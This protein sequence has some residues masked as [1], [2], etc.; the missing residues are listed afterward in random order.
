MLRCEPKRVPVKRLPSFTH[1][2]RVCAKALEYN[3]FF[4]PKKS[5]SRM[6]ASNWN[7]CTVGH[8]A[9]DHCFEITA[10]PSL[11]TKTPAHAYRTLSGGMA[12][13]ASVAAARLGAHVRLHGAVG[14]DEAGRFLVQRLTRCGVDC[15]HLQRVP[16]AASSVSAVVID[17]QGERQ[18]FNHRGDALA[19]AAPL[20]VAVLQ[21]CDVLL[22]DPRWMPGALSALRW[23][24][25]NGVPSVLDGDLSPREDL[26]ALA[27]LARWSVFSEAGL[28]SFAPAASVAEGLALAIDAGAELAAVTLGPR[29][30]CWQ[31]RGESL[32]SMPAFTVAAADTNG[33]GDAFHAALVVALAMRMADAQAMRFASATAA[34]KCQRTGG[35]AMGPDLAEVRAFLAAHA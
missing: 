7:I 10:F 14:D 9:L 15:T 22:A 25:Q 16:G 33:A 20:D 24:R 12:A 8:A 18:I 3:P 13:N 34:I 28:A 31:R 21:G 6:A 4:G 17:A 29:G 11:T 27:A 32:H 23:A 2:L 5:T 19:R 35:V 30:V 1:S 26:Q